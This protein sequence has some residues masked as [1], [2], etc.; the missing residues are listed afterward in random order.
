MW[1]AKTLTKLGGCPGWSIFAGRTFFFVMLLLIYASCK[2]DKYF[3]SLFCK[4][5][6]A[7]I[8]AFA[9]CQVHFR[10]IEQLP[11]NG[12]LTPT[13]F[14][15]WSLKDKC[16]FDDDALFM[17]AK[18]FIYISSYFIWAATWQNQQSDCAPS[19]D[20]DQPGHPSSRIRVVSPTFPFAPE[21]FRPLSLS[22][23]RFAPGS[24]RPL[25]RSPLSRFT[26]FPVRPWVVSPPY[27]IL[28]LVLLYRPQKCI[29][30][31]FSCILMIF[32]YNVL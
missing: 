25:S 27:K 22:P 20:S 21:S 26:H 28:F 7:I 4:T 19:E 3:F 8:W 16:D 30:L 6:Q 11:I 10:D 24:F 23:R 9:V 5:A 13:I 1:T 17:M 29:K 32:R 2:L 15:N 12:H 31:L 18:Y 14:L